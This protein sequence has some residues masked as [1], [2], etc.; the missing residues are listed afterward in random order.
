MKPSKIKQKTLKLKNNETLIYS[1]SKRIGQV[2]SHIV[3]V[4]IVNYRN[5]SVSMKSFIPSTKL[6]SLMKSPRS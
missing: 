5:V 3:I 1:Y 6:N 4:S 2:S